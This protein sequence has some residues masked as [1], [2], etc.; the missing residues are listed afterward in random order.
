MAA[1]PDALRLPPAPEPRVEPTWSE[2]VGAALAA[3]QLD[4]ASHLSALWTLETPDSP[5]AHIL[6]GHIAFRQ[7][8]PGRG[9]A[10]FD[11]ALTLDTSAVRRPEVRAA[12]ET[13][14][15]KRDFHLLAFIKMLNGHAD[16]PAADLLADLAK[17]A[18]RP[19]ERREAYRGL[20]RLGVDDRLDRFA[21]LTTNLR[22]N[23]T[24]HC[25]LRRW[26]V[27]RL[28]ALDDPRAA[29]ALRNE[30]DRRTGFLNLSRTAR[31]MEDRI[32]RA[33]R[34]WK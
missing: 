29:N 4:R 13:L 7:G 2:R 24:D 17:R 34:K 26:Y 21:Y 18:P 25:E 31:C 8:Q 19:R 15:A 9:I 28:I 22:R 32:E 6:H 12:I 3:D 27:Q 16:A 20:E 23:P 30:L 10:E 5:E 14:I 1:I 11:R 33:L